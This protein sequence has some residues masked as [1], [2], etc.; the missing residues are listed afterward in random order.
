MNFLRSPG[1]R[2]FFL[3]VRIRKLIEIGGQ[4]N[5]YISS[6]LLR[7]VLKYTQG[8]VLQLISC[9]IR[10]LRKY[11]QCFLLRIR[12]SAYRAPALYK[13]LRAA[14]RDQR[15]TT[16]RM[17]ILCFLAVV[18]AGKRVAFVY[19]HRLQSKIRTW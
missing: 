14:R 16:E 19:W 1:K 5:N 11:L 4:I 6:Y 8:H 9:K 15:S 3:K 18:L 2:M 17:R 7:H 12:T 10:M 13:R